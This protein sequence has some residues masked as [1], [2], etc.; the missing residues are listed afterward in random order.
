MTKRDVIA[1]IE[2]LA[3]VQH[4]VFSDAQA[5]ALGVT[6]GMLA[7]HRR[8]GGRWERVA[9]RVSAVRDGPVSPW[10]AEMAALLSLGATAVLS[11]RSAARVQR[12][13]GVGR[14]LPELTVCHGRS[15]PGWVLHRGLFVPDDGVTDGLRH[16]LP[17]RTVRDCSSVLCEDDLECLVESALRAERVT[18]AELAGLLDEP[19]WKG[20]R[21]LERVLARRPPGA[22]PTASE[23]ETRFLQVLR[24]VV[25]EPERRYLVRHEGRVVAELDDAWPEALLFAELDGTVVHGAGPALYRDRQRQNEVVRRLGWRPLRFTHD[26][27]TRWPRQVRAVVVDAYAF[28]VSLARCS[29]ALVG[30]VPA[31]RLESLRNWENKHRAA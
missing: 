30:S 22:A 23:L 27:V 3:G 24:G 19:R 28:G 31:P 4:G 11:H 10:R 13:D 29:P 14:C 26:D 2:I 25:P 9:P 6:P 20:R 12:F 5:A 15:H 8:R 18:L 17:L 21:T 7:H 16:T 1:A